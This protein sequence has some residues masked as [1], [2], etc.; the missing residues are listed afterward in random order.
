MVWLNREQ[1][2]F[3]AMLG[4]RL[5]KWTNEEG[6]G[7][8][9]D[10]VAEFRLAQMLGMEQADPA[11]RAIWDAVYDLALAYLDDEPP[12]VPPME[13]MVTDF[14]LEGMPVR[15]YSVVFRQG[16]QLPG[17]WGDLGAIGEPMS[18]QARTRAEAMRVAMAADPMRAAT[19]DL[20]L[21][22]EPC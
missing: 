9:L 3:A 1:K 4:R 7:D 19:P 14:E 20:L 2:A 5:N 21:N 22:V 12:E 6:G 11:F 18:V 15:S 16:V 8:E 13:P 17:G 10:E